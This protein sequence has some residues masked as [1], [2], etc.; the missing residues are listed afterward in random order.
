MCYSFISTSMESTLSGTVHGI[1][2]DTPVRTQR[3]C[4]CVRMCI[5]KMLGKISLNS[6]K[7]EDRQ[8][9]A[10]LGFRVSP[11]LTWGLH[12][13]T[14]TQEQSSNIKSTEDTLSLRMVNHCLA[15]FLFLLSSPHIKE[16]EE[17]QHPLRLSLG[18]SL[19]LACLGFGG[20][21]LAPLYVQCRFLLLMSWA[22]LLLSFPVIIPCSIK[23]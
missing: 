3:I 13:K 9:K 15:A 20:P 11:R 22:V 17:A 4:V 14:L 10:S 23:N 1:W 6:P 8:L 16:D 21:L 5:I 7:Q 12:K 19:R 2:D 18:P